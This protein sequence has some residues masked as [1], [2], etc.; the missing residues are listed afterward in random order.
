M[1]RPIL[2]KVS[3]DFGTYFLKNLY[4]ANFLRFKIAKNIDFD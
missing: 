3:C 1:N 2:V 4:S